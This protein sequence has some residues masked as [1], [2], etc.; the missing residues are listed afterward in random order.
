MRKRKT[1]ARGSPEFS[2]YGAYAWENWRRLKQRLQG[3]SGEATQ[4]NATPTDK[5]ALENEANTRREGG[6]RGASGGSERRRR[7]W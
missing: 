7:T 6:T 5:R 4:T 3:K 1:N 2:A